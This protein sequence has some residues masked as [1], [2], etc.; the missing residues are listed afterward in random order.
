LEYIKDTV[1]GEVYEI[2]NH[3]KCKPAVGNYMKII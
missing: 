2:I 1:P 3:V